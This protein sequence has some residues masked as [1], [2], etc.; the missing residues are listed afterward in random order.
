MYSSAEVL[1]RVDPITGHTTYTNIRPRD[2]IER[3]DKLLLP[4]PAFQEKESRDPVRPITRQRDNLE[5]K[6]FPKISIE[7]QKNRDDDRRS[8]LEAEL[9]DESA[10]MA[11]AEKQKA[12]PLVTAR[13]RR[14]IESLQ[15]EI[16]NIK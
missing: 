2:Q 8:I 11:R 15:R 12:E 10:A 16:A 3:S 6:S 9:A 5:T 14:N 4:S 7:V 1:K 13:H